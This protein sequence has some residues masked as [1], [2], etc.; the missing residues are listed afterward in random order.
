MFRSMT[1]FAAL[2]LSF[3]LFAQPGPSVTPGSDPASP[4]RSVAFATYDTLT[5]SL[6]L[7]LP[8]DDAETHRCIIY[9]Y[10]GGFAQNNQRIDE[11]KRLCRQLADDGFVVAATDYRLGLL[12]VKFKGSL[13]MVKPLE[14]ALQMAVEDV[15]KATRY[16]LD[17]AVELRVDPWQIVLM[18]CSAGA[19]TSLQ[20]D[21]ERCGGTP[22]AKQYLPDGFRYAGVISFAGAIFSRRGLEY[23]RDMPAPTLLLHG[24]ADQLVTYKQIKMFNIGLYGSN[25][26]ARKF[27]ENHY[28]YK[29]IR[30]TNEGH[31][32]ATRYF[33]QY[34]DIIW[35][36]NHM[37][38]EG[39]H[40]E[41]D[42]T[43]SDPF[44]DRPK[45]DSLDPT[46]LYNN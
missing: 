15:F 33:S 10:G 12:G 31:S 14:N 17:N 32:V 34:E 9:S 8:K 21:F 11:T 29:I 6:D 1:L 46:S 27:K 4:D 36:I 38:T 16:V 23:P 18:G 35:F 41:I 39:R 42:E 7:Y 13:S 28:P 30:F 26:I 20:C 2:L 3:T 22:L 45:W 25:S 5:L 40:F 43:F 44:R 24:T 37:V 19:M